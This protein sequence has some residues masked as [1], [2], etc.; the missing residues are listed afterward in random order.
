[1]SSNAKKHIKDNLYNN[2]A[3]HINAP[4]LYSQAC[5]TVLTGGRHDDPSLIQQENRN[6]I[7][8]IWWHLLSH[9]QRWMYA[10]SVTYVGEQGGEWGK[11]VGSMNEESQVR[12]YYNITFIYTNLETV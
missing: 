2:L 10:V 12:G 3:L 5:G 9:H 4:P 1:M 6:V 11:Q 7:R 8:L